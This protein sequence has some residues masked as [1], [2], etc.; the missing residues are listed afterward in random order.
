MKRVYQAE[1]A[2]EARTLSDERALALLGEQ[3]SPDMGVVEIANI[4]ATDG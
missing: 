3:L 2:E 4:E 1:S